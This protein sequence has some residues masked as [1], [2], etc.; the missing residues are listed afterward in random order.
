[1][2][3]CDVDEAVAEH[4]GLRDH[5]GRVCVQKT[6]VLVPDAHADFDRIGSTLRDHP[7]PHDVADRDSFKGHGSAVLQSGGVIEIAS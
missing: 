7:D 4:A 5:G 3:R 1:M 6:S 2:L